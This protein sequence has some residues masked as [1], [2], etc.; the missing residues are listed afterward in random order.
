LY[1]EVVVI[2]RDWLNVNK[3]GITPCKPS[4]GLFLALFN[5]GAASYGRFNA[6]QTF[7]AGAWWGGGGAGSKVHGV[8]WGEVV[9]WHY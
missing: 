7:T 8:G 9:E 5:K 6:S 1:I 3:L 2:Y 4:K